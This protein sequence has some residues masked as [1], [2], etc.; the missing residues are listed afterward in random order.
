MLRQTLGFLLARF[1]LYHY[2]WCIFPQLSLS[3]ADKGSTMN[4]IVINNVI[5]FIVCY[6]KA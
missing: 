6:F 5:V 3:V 4:S 2:N 1:L